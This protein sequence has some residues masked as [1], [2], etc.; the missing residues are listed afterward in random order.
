MS[1]VWCLFFFVGRH[2]IGHTI[3]LGV[4]LV[5]FQVFQPVFGVF[6]VVL[7]FFVS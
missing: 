1:V 2:L 3:F 5:G 7:F 4:D 6:L